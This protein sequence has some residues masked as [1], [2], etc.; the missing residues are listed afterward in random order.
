P[1]I[2]QAL[3]EATERGKQVAAL[4]ELKARFDEE[5]NIEWARRL[6]QA[7]VH[8]V[9]GLLGLKTHCKLTLVVRR[10][11]Q[12]LRRYVHIATG[13]YNPTSSS[14]YTDLGLFTANKEIGEDAS[15]FFNYLTGYSRQQH[16]RKLMVSHVNLREKLTELIE[17]ETA[18]AKAGRPARIV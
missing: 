12:S 14:T 15:D 4:V 17:R 7:G 9:Y 13:N 8:V 5:S 1:P 2:V 3:I 18:H 11:G 16:S 10:E 6:E